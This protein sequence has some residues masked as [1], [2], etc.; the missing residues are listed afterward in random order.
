MRVMT[1]IDLD[2]E[3]ALRTEE[4]DNIGP[5]RRLPAESQAMKL[6]V[7]NDLPQLEFGR[8]QA[9]AH[10]ASKMPVFQCDFLMRH[11]SSPASLPLPENRGRFA[12]AIYRPSR[13]GRA[14]RRVCLGFPFLEPRV[15][16][17]SVIALAMI[18][19]LA[20]LPTA[21]RALPRLPRT[22]RQLGG[23]AGDRGHVFGVADDVGHAAE[24]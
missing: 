16:Y 23:V 1:T 12:P 2:N 22:L 6:A 15:G 5:K 14:G 4:I 20:A 9:L 19:R 7:A 11:R 21:T 18:V 17:S 24:A 8:G 3:P 10:H 13:K